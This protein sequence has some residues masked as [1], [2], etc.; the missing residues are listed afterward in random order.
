MRFL[1]NSE[2]V[3]KSIKEG[4][5]PECVLMIACGAIGGLQVCQCILIVSQLIKQLTTNSAEFTWYLVRAKEP[6]LLFL[7]LYLLQSRN[8]FLVTNIDNIAEANTLR[9][10]SPEIAKQ[11]QLYQSR[12]STLHDPN[13]RLGI[14]SVNT[15]E[16]QCPQVP[17]PKLY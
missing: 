16:L 4:F 14:D 12:I 11:N 1:R 7:E 6:N 17:V 15:L 3:W 10:G 5:I 13:A 2:F 9:P 8:E